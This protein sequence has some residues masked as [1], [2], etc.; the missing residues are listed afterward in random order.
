MP[1]QPQ[2]TTL[3]CCAFC[4]RG[5]KCQGTT[6]LVKGK[7]FSPYIKPVKIA[8]ALAPEGWVFFQTETPSGLLIRARLPADTL[9]AFVN[10]KQ[11]I[12]STLADISLLICRRRVHWRF[13]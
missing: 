8:R 6:S 10:K 3:A 12:P 2:Q 5:K 13:G 9:P 7:G 1:Q 4:A 11:H